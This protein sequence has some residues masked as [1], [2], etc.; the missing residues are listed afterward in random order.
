MS[1]A[2]RIIDWSS[3]SSWSIANFFFF[4]LLF[5]SHYY[6]LQLIEIFH[7]NLN[8][9]SLYFYIVETLC[10]LRSVSSSLAHSPTGRTVRFPASLS[11]DVVRF[12]SRIISHHPP[13]NHRVILLASQLFHHAI[14]LLPFHPRRLT[15]WLAD[16]RLDRRIVRNSSE[17]RLNWQSDGLSVALFAQ[18]IY[19]TKFSS[20]PVSCF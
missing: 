11:V 14:P 2:N 18:D 15:D 12:L 16:R 4:F 8:P 9:L 7:S 10:R 5:L 1:I 17:M 3:S 13:L 6:Y 20:I 19:S